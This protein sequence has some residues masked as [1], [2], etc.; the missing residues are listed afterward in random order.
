[1]KEEVSSPDKREVNRDSFQYP[2]EFFRG[3]SKKIMK[4]CDASFLSI[5]FFPYNGNTQVAHL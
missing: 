3:K 2:L 4:V 1:M 5:G